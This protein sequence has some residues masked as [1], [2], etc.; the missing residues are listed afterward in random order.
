[1]KNVMNTLSF[2]TY[3]ISYGSHVQCVHLAFLINLF[4]VLDNSLL[5]YKIAKTASSKQFSGKDQLL[6]NCQVLGKCQLW[7]NV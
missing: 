2:S 3:A 7:A 4:V 1:M 5:S 6:A